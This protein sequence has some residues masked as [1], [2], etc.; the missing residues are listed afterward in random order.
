VTVLAT[1]GGPMSDFASGRGVRVVLDEQDLAAPPDVILVQDGSLAYRLADRWPGTP[2]VFRACSDVY[3]FV[4][5]P[6]LP[7]LVA[8]VVVA[9]DRIARRV[10]AMAGDFEIVRLRQPVDTARFAPRGEI[11]DR[12]RRAVLL[13]NYLNGRRRSLL[14]DAWER[15]G[16]DCVAV[17]AYGDVRAHPEEVIAGADIVV[18]KARAII[19]GMAC[20]RAAY[21]YDL[22]GGD[23]WVTADGYAGMEADNFGGHATDWTLSEARLAADIAAY[24]PEMGLVNRDLA[25]RHHGARGHAHALVALFERVAAAPV[26]PPA[27]LRELARLVRAQSATEFDLHRLN[28]DAIARAE[29]ERAAELRAGAAEARAAQA[30]ARA[31]ELAVE[32]ERLRCLLGTRRARA[33]LA[34]GRAAD[35]VRGR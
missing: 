8:A 34:V 33:G 7:G 6:Q 9:S 29:V 17:G 2:Q 24:R 31:A 28:A 19:D 11:R 15:A 20:G 26:A 12:P 27:P 1:V 25:V 5:P 4:L 30:E 13:G 18:G 16:V 22:Y 23:G 3:D 21:V 32:V 35:R 10:Q 14:V